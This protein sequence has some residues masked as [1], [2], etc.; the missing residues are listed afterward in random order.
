MENAV[1]RRMNLNSFLMVSPSYK[2]SKNGGSDYASDGYLR[3]R[4]RNSCYQGK[5]KCTL[6]TERNTFLL[7][8]IYN[9]CINTFKIY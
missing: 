5:R 1:L 2:L 8:H 7:N 4:T 3:T 9:Y 6:K